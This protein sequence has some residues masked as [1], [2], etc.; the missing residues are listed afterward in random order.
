MLNK[1]TELFQVDTTLFLD[2][3]ALNFVRFEGDGL[4]ATAYLKF[5]DG[6]SET[7]HGEVARTL[8]EHLT[9]L[10]NP[11]ASA[12][13]S[14]EH[15][16]QSGVAPQQPPSV[17]FE[18]SLTDNLLGLPNKAWFYR[19][20]QDGRGLILAFVNAKGSCSVRPFDAE[21]S[22]ALGKRYSSGPYQAHFA[23]LIEGATWLTVDS[24]PNLE[25]DCKQRLPQRLFDHLREQ[26]EKIA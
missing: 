14:V 3:N 6:G 21:T 1:L 26:I 11:S 2:L 25:R 24:Q 7:V 22:I 17:P 8:H 18:I 23:D 20:D 4:N 5:K 16:E 19:K 12:L 13:S 10:E 9:G 15:T